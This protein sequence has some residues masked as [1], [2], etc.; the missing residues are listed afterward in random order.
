MRLFEHEGK[1]ALARFGVTIPK[2]GVARAA[3]EAEAAAR[4]IGAPVVIKAQVLSGGRGKAGLIRPATT[5]AEAGKISALLLGREHAGERVAAVLVEESLAVAA[6]LYLG[7]TLDS[8]RSQPLLMLS[9]AGGVDIEETAARDP[10]AI[11]RLLIDP[12]S[13]LEPYRVRALARGLGLAASAA[14]AVALA[15]EGLWRAFVATDAVLAE[16]NPLG[17]TA[18]D[19]VVAL[20][21]KFD[22]DD[23]AA[24]RH[25][26]YD[27][28]GRVPGETAAERAARR[29]G[30]NYVQIDG[31]IGIAG[32]GAGMMMATVDRVASL[33]G[34]PANFCDAG[35]ARARPG[36]GEGAI[37]WWSDVIEVVLA[38]PAVEYLLFNL[39]GGN[40]RGDEVATGLL[41]GLARTRRVPM[42]VRLSGT[43]EAEGRLLL[44]AQGIAACDTMEEVALAAVALTRGGG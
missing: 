7:I 21:A 37:R 36:S 20:D 18:A 10:T 30:L 4:A 9:R 42:V 35:G 2:S 5:P 39:H 11:A 27:P 40:H 32:N 6:E 33:G 25:P 29:L 13:G 19:R 43:R 8:D 22:L 3:A 44:Q 34:R 16:I 1:A 26:E 15:A 23:Y 24:A 17:Q 31:N 14:A 28:E 12:T 41:R 38:N